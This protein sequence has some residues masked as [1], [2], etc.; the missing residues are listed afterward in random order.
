MTQNMQIEGGNIETIELPPNKIKAVL[1][2]IATVIVLLASVYLI[3]NAA[4]IAATPSPSI[5]EPFHIV[6]IWQEVVLTLVGVLGLAS[7][8]GFLLYLYLESWTVAFVGGIS[9]AVICSAGLL[10]AESM[11]SE[12]PLTTWAKDRYGIVLENGSTQI[13]KD[14]ISY[15]NLSGETGTATARKVEGGYLLYKLDG[16]KELPLKV[17]E[18]K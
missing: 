3:Y 11:S 2:N 14:I 18:N 16:S 5:S 6:V 4:N 8:A 1:V 9:M 12:S 7:V 10:A 13:S 17:G 15:T